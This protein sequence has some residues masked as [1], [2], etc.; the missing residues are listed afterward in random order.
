M[1]S[2]FE[3]LEKVEPVINATACLQREVAC[4]AAKEYD[5]KP[6][7]NGFGFIPSFAKD[8]LNIIGLPTRHGSLATPEQPFRTTSRLAKLLEGCGLSW[9]GKSRLPEFGLTATTE[10]SQSE[11]ARNPWNP[12]YSAGGSSGG[13]A[14]LVAAGVVPIAHANDA[15]GSIRIPAS[16]CGLIGLKPSRGRLLVSEFSK[17]LPIQIVSDG[18]LTRSVRDTARLYGFAEKLHK[19]KE[20]PPLGHLEGE[21]TGPL[22]IAYFTDL[23][24]GGS[25]HEDCIQAVEQTA[26]FLSS[27]GHS[28]KRVRTPVPE[29]FADDFLLYWASLASSIQ[30]FGKVLFGRQFTPKLLEPLTKELSRYALKNCLKLPFTLNRLKNF[31]NIYE[32]GFEQFDL[33]LSPTLGTPP[34]PIGY[35]SLELP[36]EIARDR[37]F[38]YACFTAAQNVSGAPGISLPVMINRDNLPIGIHLA[39]PYGR[40]ALLIE[41]AYLFERKGKLIDWSV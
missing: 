21:K 10:Y 16:C 29:K 7:F 5:E 37:L 38:G 8:N 1:A 31:S 28:L 17:D 3:R 19:N 30:Y 36:F 18:V 41:T 2:S 22:K 26:E 15:G 34:P 14:A 11:P 23:T 13:A 27:Q 25:A 4:Q 24:T 33:M 35:L 32:S 39:A 40:D 12:S 6:K 9:M 20:L